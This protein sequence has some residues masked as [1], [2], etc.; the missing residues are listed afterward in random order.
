[1]LWF[2]YHVSYI[3]FN[4]SGCLGKENV[5]LKKNEDGALS[6]TERLREISNNL[7]SLCSSTPSR[8]KFLDNAITPYS[9]QIDPKTP[10][11]ERLVERYHSPRGTFSNRSSGVKVRDA[12]YLISM[13]LI[14]GLMLIKYT[15]SMAAFSCSRVP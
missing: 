15:L 4:A 10:V 2:F 13:Q 11:M 8:V 14:V 6:L 9:S 7:R 5:P 3:L 1:M 12:I